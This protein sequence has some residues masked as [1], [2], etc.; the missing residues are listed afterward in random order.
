MSY[1]KKKL[2]T[3]EPLRTVTPFNECDVLTGSKQSFLKV[4][5]LEAGKMG[6][7]SIRKTL[8]RHEL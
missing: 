1:N 7:M 3:I 2:L 6:S 4:G 8:T 5:L